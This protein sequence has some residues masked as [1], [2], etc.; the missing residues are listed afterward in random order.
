MSTSRTS[1]PYSGASRPS[2]ARASSHRWQSGRPYRTTE[3][4]PL[5]LGERVQHSSLGRV[6]RLDPR[7][8][9]GQAHGS[10]Q[11]A[12]ERGAGATLVEV[13]PERALLIGAERSLQRLAQL[14]ADR[15]VRALGNAYAWLV[16]QVRG[17]RC[18]IPHWLAHSILPRRRVGPDT[19]AGS[20]KV[21]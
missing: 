16:L 5:T 19:S 21:E 6:R 10:P 15:L 7:E 3:R 2:S 4:P 9:T 14:L 1:K 11:R 12:I 20:V 18:E 17:A 8:L 13:G